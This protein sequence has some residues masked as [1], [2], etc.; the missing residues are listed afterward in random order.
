MKRVITALVLIPVAIGLIFWAPLWA[1]V[2][3]LGIVGVLG[4]LEYDRIAQ[5]AA[6]SDAAASSK[7]AAGSNSASGSNA[8]GGIALRLAGIVYIF[9]PL[10]CGILLWRI[11][12]H[13]LMFALLLSWI[14]DTAAMYVGKAWGRHKLAPVVSPNK[15]WEGAIAS[16]AGAAI[17]GAIYA[18]YLI[19][20][21]TLPI[22][23]TIAV[24]GNIAGQYGDLAES[25]LKRRANVK[26]SGSSLPG[27]G[28][29]LDRI[30]AMLF[31]LPAVYLLLL[32]AGR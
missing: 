27:H 31:A 25:W 15:T 11:S 29:W 20:R 23:L 21:A 19:P 9:G 6:S 24:I 26:D 8:A 30:D 18:G 2:A 17:G 16:V 32:A 22:V 7:A 4:W 5:G 14:G 10:A 13:W 12:P 1:L 28:G 3:A